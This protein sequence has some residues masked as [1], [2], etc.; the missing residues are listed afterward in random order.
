M[1]P[2]QEKPHLPEKPREEVRTPTHPPAGTRP[3]QEPA[4]PDRAASELQALGEPPAAEVQG[5]ESE[6]DTGPTQQKVQHAAASQQDVTQV[7][8]SKDPNP[9]DSAPQNASNTLDTSP[10]GRVRRCALCFRL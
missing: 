4:E 5:L 2:A 6:V 1:S 8:R 3:E 7:N 10:A 9:E